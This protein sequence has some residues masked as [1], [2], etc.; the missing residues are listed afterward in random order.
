MLRTVI[1]VM[2]MSTL[3]VVVVVAIVARSLSRFGALFRIWL[4][5]MG[6]IDNMGRDMTVNKPRDDADNDYTGQEKTY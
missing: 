3:I 6:T 4:V 2:V 1:A 5:R